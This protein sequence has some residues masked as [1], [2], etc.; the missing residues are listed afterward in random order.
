MKQGKA[1][2]RAYGGKEEALGRLQSK[3]LVKVYE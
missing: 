3:G 2:G 1:A